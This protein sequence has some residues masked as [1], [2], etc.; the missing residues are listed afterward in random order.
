MRP[1]AVIVCGGQSRR[2]G[3]TKPW[4]PFGPER[5]LSRVAR[6]VATVADPIAVVAA[7][8]Q[9]LPPLP[10]SAIV[11]RD[12]ITGRG[13]LQGLA[14]GLAALPDSVEFVYASAT[15]VPFLEP[16]WVTALVAMV[17]DRD[18][19]IPHVTGYF[20][21]LAALYRRR[22]VL[23]V[24][25]RLLAADQLRAVSLTELVRTRV[26]GEAELRAVDPALGTIRNLNAPADYHAALRAAGYDPNVSRVTIEL[27]GAL[28]LRAGTDRIEVKAGSVGS[29]LE[30]LVKACP[31]LDGAVLE[32]GT[33]HSSYT[34]NLNGAQFVTDPAVPLGEG[35]TLFLRSA[36][37]GD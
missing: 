33:L 17:A 32:G 31:Q 29:A 6:L 11:A 9:E 34:L 35:D 15:D 10:S 3:R 1:A 5:L 18:L 27:T 28:R 16:A 37:A 20:Q 22:T 25:E 4:L 36:D 19:V 12:A 8:A 26:V 24:V 2:M 13:P 23:P 21:P 14:A 7:P 30:A